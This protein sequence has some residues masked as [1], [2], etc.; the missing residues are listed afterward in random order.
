MWGSMSSWLTGALGAEEGLSNMELFGM[1]KAQG[2]TGS[3][4]Y[5][6][7]EQANAL[8]FSQAKDM[9]QY[10]QGTDLG[11]LMSMA[12]TGG[13]MAPREYYRDIQ[14]PSAGLMMPALPQQPNPW[15]QS[16]Y[17]QQGLMY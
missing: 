3:G 8:G 11:G 9:S 17:W 10:A 12:Q 6:G 2:L 15:T 14:I 13:Q 7:A 4:K 1:G 5:H 16:P